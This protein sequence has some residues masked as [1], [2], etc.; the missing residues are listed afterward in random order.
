MWKKLRK[1][2]ALSHNCSSG[3]HNNTVDLLGCSCCLEA[4]PAKLK[5]ITRLVIENTVDQMCFFYLEEVKVEINGNGNN[6]KRLGVYL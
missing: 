1:S 6:H 3:L 2:C 5:A 4:P